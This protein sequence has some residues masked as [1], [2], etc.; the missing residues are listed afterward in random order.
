MTT[1]AAMALRQGGLSKPGDR[2]GRDGRQQNSLT[3]FPISN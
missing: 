1:A 3:H 2:N